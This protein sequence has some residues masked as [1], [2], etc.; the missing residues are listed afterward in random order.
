[1]HGLPKSQSIHKYLDEPD[2]KLDEVTE[3]KK[4]LVIDTTVSDLIPFIKN[5]KNQ[6]TVTYSSDT[7]LLMDN[8][9]QNVAS[10]QANATNS[11]G[12]ESRIVQGT[13]EKGHG[14]TPTSILEPMVVQSTPM[15]NR[16]VTPEDTN[17][18]KAAGKRKRSRSLSKPR[19]TQ[20]HN[21][22]TQ[23]LQSSMEGCT[24]FPGQKKFGTSRVYP[25][26]ELL[27]SS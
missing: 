18:H 26:R 25:A 24:H 8:E 2:A 23:S 15:D 16:S 11:S 13:G 12:T 4:N 19:V 9:E 5:M 3:L 22:V 6:L 17:T 14:K 7:Q 21:K 1:M 27:L 10:V 20:K